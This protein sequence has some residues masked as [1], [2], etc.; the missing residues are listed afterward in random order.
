MELIHRIYASTAQPSFR[1][2]E[3]PLLLEKSRTNNA[4]RG[5]TGMLLYI[6]GSFFQVL[7][8][9]AVDV[10]EVFERIVR[11]PRHTRVTTIIREPIAQRRFG[12]WTMGHQTV[13]PLD[14]GKLIGENDFFKSATCVTQL[15][16]GRAKKLLDAFAQGTWRLQRTG[17]HRVIRR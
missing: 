17:M 8:G 5:L 12:D 15:G 11:D 3:I 14:A 9:N 10:D 7:E 1:E 6:Q 4:A 13:D 16:S 2:S